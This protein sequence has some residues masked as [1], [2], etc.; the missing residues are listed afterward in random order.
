MAAAIDPKRPKQ[1][2]GQ[3]P[4]L[5]R[6]ARKKPAPVTLGDEAASVMAFYGIFERDYRERLFRDFASFCRKHDGWVITPSHQGLARVQVAEGAAPALLEKIAAL[7]RYPVAISP[8]V[9]QHRLQFGRFIPVTELTCI[10][11]R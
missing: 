8:N 4:R 3:H 9:S 10:L 1:N 7:K 5:A 11:W 6:V 2:L